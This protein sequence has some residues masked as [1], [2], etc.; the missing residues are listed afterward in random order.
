MSGIIWQVLRAIDIVYG[1]QIKWPRGLEMEK[2]IRDFK[3]W[4]SL[5]N[6]HGDIDGTH[7]SIARLPSAFAADYYYFKTGG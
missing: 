7:I 5:P 4:C 6:I 2:V 1:D 3:A